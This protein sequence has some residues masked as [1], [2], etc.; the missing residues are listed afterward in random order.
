MPSKIY[1]GG[2][3]Y[4]DTLLE[5]YEA[6]TYFGRN[7]RFI[8]ERQSVVE[9]LDDVRVLMIPD[10]LS[11]SDAAFDIV[12][13]Y[14]ED[15]GYA[16][17]RGGPIPY[18]EH[19]RSRTGV[20]PSTGRTILVRGS[21]RTSDYLNALDQAAGLGAFPP[22]PRPVNEYGYPLEGVVARGGPFEDGYCLYVVNLREEPVQ[23]VLANGPDT[24]LDLIH[25]QTVTF[26]AVLEPLRPMILRLPE[27]PGPDVV[28]VAEPE[29]VP[30][31]VI[32]PVLPAP[33]EGR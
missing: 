2:A 13:R 25:E 15:G 9:G 30:T 4:L 22:L 27:P 1:D 29:G 21:I 31:A 24:A 11:M 20:L 14:I 16:V 32:E 17:R 8:S 6:A 12:L 5:A 19:G 26:P 28:M 33:E 3:R 7:V 18:D 10:M 23:A